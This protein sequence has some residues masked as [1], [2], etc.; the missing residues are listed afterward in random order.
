MKRLLLLLILTS[1]ISILHAQ[2][3]ANSLYASAK[4]YMQQGNLEKALADL[5]KAAA[6]Q[7]DNAAILKDQAYVAYLS[8]DYRTS[9]DA[10]KKLIARTDA[11]EQS[12]QLLGLAYRGIAEYKEGEKMYEDGLKRFPQSGV[13]YNE[14]AEMQVENNK[15]DD[16]I[17]LWEKGIQADANIAGNY[18]GAAKY[19]AD[20]GNSFWSVLY[21][22]MFI[23][24]ESFT[25]RSSEV[26]MIL[27]KQYNM[28]LNDNASL[29]K[30][31]SKGSDF[32]K[33]VASTLLKDKI[34]YRT[35]TPDTLTI[36][37][38]K[39]VEDWHSNNY[40]KTVPFR[41]FE[42]HKQ[43]I[44]ANVFDAYNQWLFGGPANTTALKLWMQSH[45]ADVQAL[46]QFQQS[47]LFKVPQGQYYMH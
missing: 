15:K 38:K 16:A 7:P 35:L 25:E 37:R 20:N 23:N 46:Q 9:I 12:Y 43:L 11:D 26:K 39:F 21:G 2:E 44:N 8:R 42:Y 1:L 28:L 4:T 13:L 47:L 19:Y 22:E 3:D 29:N 24:I 31:A 45:D 32:E 5:N 36:I 6:L 33:A 10:G 14:F 17:K 27:Y 40:S 30:L 34:A 18:Y 41:L